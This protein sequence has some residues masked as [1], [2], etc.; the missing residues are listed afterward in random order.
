MFMFK[1]PDLT[2]RDWNTR[3]FFKAYDYE[4]TSW[5]GG[6]KLYKKTTPL[7]V[8]EDVKKEYIITMP[9][10]I[11]LNEFN[12]IRLVD[13]LEYV[14][15]NR[16]VLYLCN[17]DDDSKPIYNFNERIEKVITGSYT[18]KLT[19]FECLSSEILINILPIIIQ[20]LKNEEIE[21]KNNIENYMKIK[22]NLATEFKKVME[23]I[24]E[25]DE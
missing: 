5:L 9:D 20:K 14:S 22:R 6:L 3:K 2:D 10:D 16:D 19:G 21:L 11:S 17:N 15:A 23:R 18:K 12:Y 7:S 24:A 13:V 8:N 1:Q 4:T 25:F